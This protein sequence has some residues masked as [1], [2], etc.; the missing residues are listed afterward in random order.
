MWRIEDAVRFGDA[1]AD[2]RDVKRRYDRGEF[3]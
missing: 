3:D 2:L 1:D